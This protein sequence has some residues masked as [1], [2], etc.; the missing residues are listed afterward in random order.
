MNFVRSKTAN[1]AIGF[2]EYSYGLLSG[3]PVAKVE[4]A[5][6]FFTLPSQYA[7]AVALTQAIINTDPTSPNY[8]LQDLHEV[9]VYSD[10]G[11]YPLSSYSYMILP[12]GTNAQ[13]SQMTTP[14]RQTI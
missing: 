3:T 14:K 12:I 10:P 13:D 8:L 6:G 9:Y 7:V 11:T 4:N 1:G 2:D 5:A